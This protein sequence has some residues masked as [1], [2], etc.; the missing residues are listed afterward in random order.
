ME[1]AARALGELAGTRTLGHRYEYN[2][3]AAKDSETK[4]RAFL[5]RYLANAEFGKIW[6]SL[7]TA[8]G[9]IPQAKWPLKLVR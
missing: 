6:C 4:V 5:S 7:R 9:A 8:F 2:R 3:S 1:A